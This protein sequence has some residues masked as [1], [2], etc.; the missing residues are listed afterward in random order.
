MMKSKELRCIM[1]NSGNKFWCLG[2]NLHHPN[3]P[4]VEWADGDKEWWF[5]GQRFS[6]EQDLV[7]YKQLFLLN[8]SESIEQNNGRESYSEYKLSFY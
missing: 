5:H 4:A 2:Q 8:S 7:S 1:D 3:R 6:S